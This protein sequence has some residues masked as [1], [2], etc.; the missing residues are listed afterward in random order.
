MS[1]DYVH[2]HDK[3]AS[4]IDSLYRKHR[5]LDDHIQKEFDKFSNDGIIR[6]LKNQKLAIKDEIARY[7]AELKKL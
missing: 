2:K 6:Q 7:E 4:H 5:E 1:S 3:L